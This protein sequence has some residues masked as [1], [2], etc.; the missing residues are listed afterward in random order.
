MSTLRQHWITGLA[1]LTAA[2]L[3]FVGVAFFVD[4]GEGEYRE[5]V[6]WGTMSLLGAAALNHAAD[7]PRL[8]RRPLALTSAGRGGFRGAAGTATTDQT[9]RARRNR[10]GRGAVS[11]PV[12]AHVIG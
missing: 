7:G 5:F 4:P 2:F 6:F 11:T 3:A 10:C 1:V 9:T 8:H 12:S